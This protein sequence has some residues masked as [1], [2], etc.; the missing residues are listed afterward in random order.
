LQWVAVLSTLSPNTSA[1]GRGS[2][3]YT[4]FDGSWSTTN[5]PPDQFRHQK[6]EYPYHTWCAAEP[7]T[8]KI[9]QNQSINQSTDR[10]HEWS[11]QEVIDFLTSSFSTVFL[12]YPINWTWNTMK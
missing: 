10:Q 8:K 7:E 2:S 1:I 11:I 5:F 9:K 3:L 12:G 6:R 4:L